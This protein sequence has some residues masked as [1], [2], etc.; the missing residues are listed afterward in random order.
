M[1]WLFHVKLIFYLCTK[2]RR[3]FWTS[4]K[5]TYLL[6]VYTGVKHVLP[7][8]ATYK[9][10]ELVTLRDHLGSPPVLVDPW[11]LIF[12]LVFCAVFLFCFVLSSSS[13]PNVENLSG[14]LI[15][16]SH[17]G[18]LWVAHSWLPLRFS[19]GCSF[20][21]ATSVL[22]GLL[23][24]D[25]HFGSLWVAHSWLPLRFSLGCSFS[26]ATSVLSYVYLRTKIVN[27]QSK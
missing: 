17:F 20:L 21:I 15:L 14:L 7:I 4:D 1:Y 22:S 13:V 12:F 18:S 16:D 26:I 6:F 19:L 11:L 25:C 23:I 24:L 27:I 10:Q 2:V 5:L 3:T 9:R 8:W